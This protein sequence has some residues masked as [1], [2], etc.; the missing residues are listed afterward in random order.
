MTRDQ[1][2][3]CAVTPDQLLYTDNLVVGLEDAFPV[4][5]G[6]ALVAP[7]RHVP[8]WFD[9]TREERIALV[10]A[11]EYMKDAIERTHRPDGY[12]I[13]VNVGRAAG[14]TVFHLHV[15]V[16]PRYT[17]DLT[18]PRGG[19]RAVIPGRANYL[20]TSESGTRAPWIGTA[21]HE[22]A[23]VHGGVDDPLLAHLAAHLDRATAVDLAVSFT[24]DSGVRLI[25]PYLRD[26]LD[27]GGRVRL[28]TGDYLGVTEPDALLR[29]TDLEG[30]VHLRIFESAGRSFHPKAYIITDAADVGTAFV[31]SSNLSATALR[32]GVEWNYRVLTASS[33]SG[34]GDVTAGFEALFTH[35]QTSPLDAAW[36]EAYRKRRVRTAIQPSGVAPEPPPIPPEPH[37]VQRAALAQLER[38]R[39]EGNGAGLVVLATGLGKTWL[40]A[41]DSNRS[42]FARVLF[43]AH[44]EEILNQA[45]RTFRRVRPSAV[46]GHYTGVEKTQ[47]AEV[48]FASIQTLGRIE[49]LNKFDPTYFDYIVI[50]E[51]HHAAA[52]TYRRLLDHFRPQFLLGLTAT[53]ERTDGGDLL[54]L[55]GENLVYRCDL[56][57]GIRRGLLSQFDY[58]GVPDEVDY[59]NIPWRSSRFD[60]EALTRAVA[61]EKRAQNAL[62]Q[63]RQR[64]GTRTLAFCVSQRHADFMAEYFGAAGVRTV[65]VHSGA[66]SA[67]RSRSLEQLEAGEIQVLFAV[68]MFNEGVDLP[69]VDTVMMLRPTESQ[70]LWLQQ[71]GRGLRKIGDKRLTVIDY[72]GNHRSFLIKPRTLLQLGA[73]DA[74]V[75][76]ALDSLEAGTLELP[77]G[78]SVT[79]DLEAKDILRALLRIPAR[80]EALRAYYLDFRERHGIRPQAVEADHDGHDP[81]SVRPAHPSWIAFVRTMGDLSPAQAAVH[82]KLGAFFDVLETTPMT[83]SYKMVLLL[84]MLAEDALPGRIGLEQLA[85]RFADL[86]RRYAGVR[87]ELATALDDDAQLAGLLENNPIDAWVGGRGTG[88]TSY[89]TYEAGVFATAF[90]APPPLREA[91]QDLVREIVE[92]RLAVYLRR[93]GGEGGA[94]RIVCK[95]SHSS[96]KPILFYEPGRDKVGGIPEG[97]REVIANGQQLQAHFVKIALNVVVEPGARQNVLPDLLRGWFG[98]NA[99]QPGTSDHII[100]QKAE[101][102]RYNMTPLGRSQLPVTA[103]L[104]Q[105]YTRAEV[106]ERLGIKLAGWDKQQGIL[107]RPGLILLFVTLDKSQKAESHQYEDEFLSPVEFQWQS[108]NRNTQESALGQELRDHVARGT[109]V[110]LCVRRKERERG[111]T[112]PFVYCGE[113]VFQRWKGTGP[114][115]VWWRMAEPLPQML[116]DEMG[117]K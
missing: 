53:P 99:G 84:A 10:D 51:F 20:S 87:T 79:Y 44:R 104:W 21:P 57:E 61:T 69:R 45:L 15:H 107:V 31:G 17:G 33:H 25:E 13:G 63:F 85:S 5:V 88:G 28:V 96:G 56:V 37:E 103:E 22:R 29:L 78:C 39:A 111:R 46:L 86:S 7:R 18:D 42:Q 23:L 76:Y 14:Q 19:I 113:L 11:I 68:D 101:G 48:M 116:W 102:G 32:E 97:W 4:S 74:D 35:R 109:H 92:W 90:A 75:R 93:V 73:G 3:F 64:A 47:D 81:K 58:Y 62:E 24:L 105:R 38:S 117:L 89:F 71:F 72:I 77:P 65:A 36:I 6:H 26:V 80:G 110:H 16:I 115:T 108:Q 114:I 41:F 2:P 27:R 94:D 43:V 30:D 60:E 50:D 112:L 67:P 49:H 9:A 1:C 8:S 82:E 95:V 54:A 40:S 66:G 83:K 55:C 70:I 52:R 12:N 100:L 106:A 98:P 34:F 91:L 59:R